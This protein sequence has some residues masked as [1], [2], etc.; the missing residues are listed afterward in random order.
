MAYRA[1]KCCV[2][3]Q[4]NQIHS[5][6]AL[7]VLER[8]INVVS[9]PVFL[10]PVAAALLAGNAASHSL[11][12]PSSNQPSPSGQVRNLPTHSWL[13]CFRTSLQMGNL[14]AGF[15][16]LHLDR[17]NGYFGAHCKS[18]SAQSCGVFNRI[19]QDWRFSLVWESFGTDSPW[20]CP[21][22]C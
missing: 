1:G 15:Y 19:T 8:L 9:E 2:A 3:G 5:Q 14:V 18:F 17:C 16:R 22:F 13:T 20:C 6:C 21:T 4:D 7:L 12:P 11:A 10:W